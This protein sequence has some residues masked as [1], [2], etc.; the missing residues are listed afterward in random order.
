VPDPGRQVL[1]AE[2]ILIL[3]ET[4]SGKKVVPY[5]VTWVHGEA[6]HL[7]NIGHGGKLNRV[8][9]SSDRISRTALLPVLFGL[10]C[11]SQGPVTACVTSQTTC[12]LDKS[13]S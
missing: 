3:Y 5:S 12:Q 6:V 8:L 7:A 11:C 1:P 9:T 4:C 2:T 10:E 13:Y